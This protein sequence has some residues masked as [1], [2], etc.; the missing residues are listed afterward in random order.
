[1]NLLARLFSKPMDPGKV[2]EFAAGAMDR[3]NFTNQERA[4]HN[5]KMADAVSK[6]AAETLSESTDRSITRRYLA[7]GI[8]SLYIFLTILTIVLAF[9]DIEKAKL[10]QTIMADYYLTTAFIMILAFF[11]GGYYLNGAIKQK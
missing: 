2:I 5:I 4:E 1:M 10:V 11:F 8:I 9:F 7:L 6:Y 3:I